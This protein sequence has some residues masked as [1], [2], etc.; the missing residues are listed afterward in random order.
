[1]QKPISP[2]ADRGPAESGLF[3]LLLICVRHL[4]LLIL[5]PLAVGAATYGLAYLLPKTYSSTAIVQ[6]PAPAPMSNKAPF[7]T[8]AQVA[9]M[10]TSV[11]VLD[12]VI[13]KFQLAE[14]V[15]RDRARAGLVDRVRPTVGR[16]LL[17]R[18]EV[19]GNTPECARATAEAVLDSWLKSTVPSAR[20]QADLKR[21]LEVA[22][23]GFQRAQQ[24][25]QHLTVEEPAAA[26]KRENGL[27][28][29]AIGEL[30]DKYLEQ[31]LGLP[32]ELEGLPPEIVRQ[33]PTLPTEPVGPRKGML[34]A[35]AA[36]FTGILIIVVLALRHLLEVSRRIPQRAEKLR[37]LRAALRFGRREKDS[38]HA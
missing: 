19:L 5:L 7:M 15:S 18:L 21:R 14:K 33:A 12:P 37:R 25:I 3:D 36:V 27:A 11:R 35:S 8:P 29:A 16:D 20:E 17:V 4:P 26:A 38:A 22:T 34:A 10:M 23:A 30:A 9:A 1:M 28:P 24:A 32:H 2:P 13:D 31:M 6:I